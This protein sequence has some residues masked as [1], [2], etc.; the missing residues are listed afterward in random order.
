MT[1]EENLSSSFITYILILGAK[2]KEPLWRASLNHQVFLSDQ[3]DNEVV[4]TFPF[5][6]HLTVLRSR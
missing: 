5:G 1:M 6:S 3:F 4:F 2:L